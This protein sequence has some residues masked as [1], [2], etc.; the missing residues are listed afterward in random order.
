M[1]PKNV[2]RSPLR[3]PGGKSSL[4]RWVKKI[5]ELNDLVGIS[6]AEPFAGG[7][8]IALSLL[9][10][11]YVSHI[12]LNDLDCAVF[13]FWSCAL[14]ETTDLCRLIKDTPV[15]VDEWFREKDILSNPIDHSVLELGFATF[16]LNRTNRSGIIEGGIIGGLDQTGNYKMD[17]RF[18][19]DSLIRRIEE[20]ASRK[21]DISLTRFDAIEFIK[22]VVNNSKGECLS[23][24]DPPYYKKGHK[25]YFNSLDPQAHLKLS[26]TIL[27]ELRVPWIVTYDDVPE[28]NMMYS[29]SPKMNYSI[30]YSA[31]IKQK[32]YEVMFHSPNLQVF[33]LNSS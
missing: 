23:F 30:N 1:P 3:Y 11:K 31:H 26:Q 24:V 25:L 6:Y 9:A 15:T 33:A 12:F 20:V 16:F 22:D 2:Y 17:C 19:K 28:I 4:S 32:G 14:E 29:S 27:N 13:A 8:G 5:I 10:D 7:A 18:N 21:N